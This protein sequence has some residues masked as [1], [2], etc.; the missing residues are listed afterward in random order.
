MTMQTR[1]VLEAEILAALSDEPEEMTRED[2]DRLRARVHQIA[3]E[4]PGAGQTP[5]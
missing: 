3:A 4:K 1:E 5:L 2:W